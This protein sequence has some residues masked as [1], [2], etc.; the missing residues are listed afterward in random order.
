MAPEIVHLD[1]ADASALGA[2][3]R[4]LVSQFRRRLRE[5]RLTSAT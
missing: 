5:Q 4:V 3:L 1:L 2:E